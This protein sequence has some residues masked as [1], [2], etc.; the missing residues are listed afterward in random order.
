AGRWR[1]ENFGLPQYFRRGRRRGRLIYSSANQY[2]VPSAKFR[3][4]TADVPGDAFRFFNIAERSCYA[5]QIEVRQTADFTVL[6]VDERKRIAVL[7]ESPRH[8]LQMSS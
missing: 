2:I 5:F 8:V 7:A 4:H 6:G 1:G 3:N